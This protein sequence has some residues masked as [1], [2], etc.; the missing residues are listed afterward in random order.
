MRLTTFWPC[1]FLAGALVNSG[2][3]V[4][5]SA[6]QSRDTLDTKVTAN[7]NLILLDWD[8]KHL[9]DAEL[10]ARGASLVAEYRTKTHGTV[11]ELLSNATSTGH[12]DRTLRFRL[13]ETMKGQPLGPVCLYIK[14]T[15]QKILPIR[16]SDGKGN[17]TARFRDESWEIPTVKRTEEAIRRAEAESAKV[18]LDAKDRDI[19]A[20]TDILA[21]K[22]WGS[23]E[24]CQAIPTPQLH[25]TERPFDVLDPAQQEDAARRVCISRVVWDRDYIVETR[26]K[27]K[28]EEDADAKEIHYAARLVNFSPEYYGLLLKKWQDG[29]A[30][31]D[32]NL[33]S[34][35]AEFNQFKRDWQRWQEKAS[36]YAKP[37]FG[38]YQDELDLQTESFAANERVMLM[39]LNLEKKKP[40]PPNVSVEEIAGY[41]GGSMEAYSR[42]VVDGQKQLHAKY[43]SWQELQAKAPELNRAAHDQLVA[44]CQRDV[45]TLSRLKDERK[46]LADLLV[47]DQQALSDPAAVSSP[48]G[49]PRVLNAVTCQP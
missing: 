39:L 49:G 46:K 3:W 9:W 34:R 26:K 17:D 10:L 32:S 13:P 29:A 11:A 33:K 35:E 16:R 7:G 42:C 22:N 45:T 23:M 43:Q 40:G 27:A 18:A 38:A 12:E 5:R 15:S 24:S 36:G 6:A 8:K 31:T 41:V 25:S 37:V 48:A 4:S 30:G 28:T 21:R 2:C 47:A 44:A 20:Q 1:A 19:A 14:L